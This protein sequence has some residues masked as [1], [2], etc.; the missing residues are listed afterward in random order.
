MSINM[1]SR[2]GNQDVLPREILSGSLSFVLRAFNE[3]YSSRPKRYIS[4]AFVIAMVLF[5]TLTQRSTVTH[6]RRSLPSVKLNTPI[7]TPIVNCNEKAAVAADA[8]IC[9]KIGRDILGRNGSAVDAAIA[10]LLCVSVINPQSMGIGGG[11]VFTIYNAINGTVEIINARETAPMSATANMF[12]KEPQ[13]ENPGLLIAVP[14]ELRGYKMA[15]DRYGK[16]PWKDLFEP[17][18]KLASEGFNISKGLA[19][20]I[21]MEE[22]KIRKNIALREVF[23]DS[24]NKPLKESNFTRFPKLA[25]TYRTIAEEGPDAFYDG[26]LTQSILD[27]ITVAGGNITREDLKRYKPDLQKYALNFTVGKY[28][29]FAPTAPFGGPVLALIMKIL[30]G[31]GTADS[32]GFNL[33]N[34]SV[35]TPENMTLTYHRIIEA[36]RFANAQKAKLADPLHEKNVTEFVKYMTSDSF[37]DN[38]RSKIKDDIKQTSYNEQG[39]KIVPDDHGTSHLSVI[40]KDG[41]AVAVTSSINNF[42]GSG[43]MSCLR[44]IIFNDQM[45]D[46]TSPEMKNG[47]NAIKPGKRPLSSMCPTIILDKDSRK[48]RM[49]AGGAGG[50]NITTSVAQVILDHLYFDYNLQKAV[51][52]PRVQVPPNVTNV[53]E[54]F[55]S[56]VMGWLSRK[57]HNISQYTSLTMVQVVEK[58]GSQ[59]CAVSDT[60]DAVYYRPSSASVK[61]LSSDSYIIICLG[62][63]WMLLNGA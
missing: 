32:S 62:V 21:N 1:S 11:S 14:G 46:Y 60:R 9:S 41:S 54:G 27:E 58:E 33:S 16:L 44:G 26:S 50:T 61:G 53:E 28:I 18:I 30:L 55:D 10:A 49:V 6:T 19:Y 51:A 56:T 52:E 37:A 12:D 7:M 35:S 63:L 17:S 45:S 29:F 5:L 25:K 48:V 13:K 22:R 2:F 34:K 20:A 36:F 38:I 40:A 59:V 8:E 57:Y 42:F 47:P 23:C 39:I 43:V 24:D 4:I 3:L 15:H 31:N